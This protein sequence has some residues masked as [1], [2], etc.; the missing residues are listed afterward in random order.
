MMNKRTDYDWEEVWEEEKS[1]G[2]ADYWDD[3]PRK[4]IPGPQTVYLIQRTWLAPQEEPVKGHG[5]VAFTNRP[6]AERHLG[7]MIERGES[8]LT[9][10]EMDLTDPPSD[11]EPK[12]YGE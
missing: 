4:P 11:P 2:W 8:H 7:A 10:V 1:G 6:D 3:S 5:E 12:G 9:I